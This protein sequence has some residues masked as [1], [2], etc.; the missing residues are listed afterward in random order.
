M[1]VINTALWAMAPVVFFTGCTSTH[2]TGP[3]GESA[4]VSGG[5]RTAKTLQEESSVC[6]PHCEQVAYSYK[7]DPNKL[8]PLQLRPAEAASLKA[9]LGSTPV[10]G[11]PDTLHLH[12]DAINGQLVFL[13]DSPTD[14]SRDSHLSGSE[15]TLR[16]P[17][18]SSSAAVKVVPTPAALELMRHMETNSG[19]SQ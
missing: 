14:P 2:Q 13:P 19:P 1:K 8:H 15:I 9:A 11:N 17:Q 16:N 7:M 5:A 6:N 10:S 3:G 18:A 12:A 4:G